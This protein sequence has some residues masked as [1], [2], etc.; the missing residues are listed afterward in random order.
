MVPFGFTNALAT[1]IC[2]MNNGFSKYLD[3]FV[4]I[5]LD[6]ILIYSEN[7]EE[8]VEHLRLTL[9]LLRKHKL[10]AGLRK[11]D[12]YEDRIHYL[13][14]LILDKGIS[15]DP[16]NIEAMMSWPAPRKLTNIRSFVGL[17]GYCRNLTKEDSVG[18]VKPMYRLR[19]PACEL[20]VHEE[21]ALM[22]MG[23]H[24]RTS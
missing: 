21:V 11:C 14:H 4:L 16:D 19:N 17:A 12:F 22:C 10:Y 8:H 15:R 3:R 9:K 24:T 23:M 7:E 18:K 1:F 5:F 6:S 20:V 13:G 2:L